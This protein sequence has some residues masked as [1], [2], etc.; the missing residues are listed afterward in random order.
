[1]NKVR[2][3]SKQELLMKKISKLERELQDM[4]EMFAERRRLA[5]ENE[6]VKHESGL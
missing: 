4:K 5:K 1:V 2:F 3:V 6:Q